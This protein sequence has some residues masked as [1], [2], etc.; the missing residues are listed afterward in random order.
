MQSQVESSQ[1]RS[2]FSSRLFSLGI[3]AIVFGLLAGKLNLWST[4]GIVLAGNGTFSL[5]LGIALGLTGLYLAGFNFKKLQLRVEVFATGL[6]VIIFSDWL[7]RGYNLFQG[8]YIRGELL[9]V[10][11]ICYFLFIGPLFTHNINSGSID[12]CG[13]SFLLFLTSQMDTLFFQTIT[14]HSCTG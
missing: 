2:V 14:P 6:I 9:L 4:S 11:I 13:F 8:P 5:L 12:S 1:N 3:L 7:C 10:S